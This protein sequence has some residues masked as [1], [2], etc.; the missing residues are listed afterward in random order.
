[1]S[2][3]AQTQML[4][5]LAS[6]TDLTTLSDI[7]TLYQSLVDTLTE[8]NHLYYVQNSPI[9][10]DTQYDEL[11]DF[12]LRIE[13]EF[14]HLISNNSPT[15]SLVG[16]IAEG[17]SK[18]D[19]KVPL[20]SLENSYN[21]ADL[22]NFDERIK[23]LLAKQEI[24]E[25]Q[26]TIEPKYDGISVELI[27]QEG[28]FVQAITRGDGYTG[29]D[30][31]TNVKTIKN[32]PKK[33]YDVPA[34]LSIRGEIMMS[35]SV[36]KSLNLQR[37]QQGKE[38]FANTRN[39]TAGSIKLLDSGE[40]AKRNLF[41]FVYDVLYAE[42]A[43]GESVG[44]DIGSSALPMMSFPASLTQGYTIEEICLNPA[45]KAFLDS[46]DFDFD[47]LVIKVADTGYRQLLGSTMH[48]PR[49]GI[50]YKF[51][52]EQMSTQILSVDFQVGRSGI[53]TP[54]AN[55]RPVKVSGVEISRASLHNFDFI[56]HKDIRQL[57][58]VWIQRSGEVIPHIMGVIKERRTGE[59][60]LIQAPL[61]CPSCNDPVINSGMHYYCTNPN[62][63]AQVKEKIL[64]F[65]S[66]NAMNIQGIGEGVVDVLVDKGIMHNVA[67]MYKLEDAALRI[68][69]RK[70]PGF[71]DRKIYEI[72][73]QVKA[74]KKQ[75]LWRIINALGIP[76][77]GEKT[78]Q[79]ICKLLAKE[80]ADS[81]DKMQAILTDSE[82]VIMLP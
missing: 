35:K 36:W 28:E 52:A 51:P 55:L 48:H 45:I 67:D 14:P 53:I 38:L 22:A 77:V 81:L 78:S 73:K 18:A 23:K 43:E 17:F 68:M 42:N 70:F 79:D 25:Y 10:S 60:Q 74:S 54:V 8:H 80:Q 40:V 41:C 13:A 4:Q 7:A 1:M 72:T 46:Q 71:G 3:S 66:K 57:D 6:T 31:T 58:V 11:F 65:V 21:P 33:L 20:L 5:E 39:A 12:L 69:L 16:Q 44:Y 56:R 2:L 29:E 64:H 59:E 61:F 9:I 26:Y 62:C 50:A 76:H 63:P 82:K 37:E 30:I 34:L 32:L 15:Q 19:H 24:V 27:Y 49:W 75:P 47:G